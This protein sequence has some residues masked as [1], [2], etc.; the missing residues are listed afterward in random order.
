MTT[1]PL[2]E[3]YRQHQEALRSLLYATFSPTPA[4]NVGDVWAKALKQLTHY[5]DE[6]MTSLLCDLLQQYIEWEGV[7]AKP[8]LWKIHLALSK[9]LSA[10]P[11]S[12]LTFFWQ[13][14]D[15][16]TGAERPALDYGLELLSAEHACTHLIVGLETCKTHAPRQKI[17]SALE[18]VGDQHV[19]PALAQA[20]RKAGEHD[21]TLARFM[22]RA[23]RAIHFR[24]CQAEERTLLRASEM[25]ASELL[26]VMC[27]PY[28]DVSNLLQPPKETPHE[29]NGTD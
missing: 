29:Q 5:S 16:A 7:V 13:K 25:P 15:T 23:F 9:T 20:Y 17:V 2:S 11:P 1:N 8:Q 14:M 18:K 21:W 3:A 22:E 28:Y 4:P 6:A 19:L 24:T 27:T 26:R 10:F 12:A